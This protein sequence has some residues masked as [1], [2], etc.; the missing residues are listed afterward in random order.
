MSGLAPRWSH[1]DSTRRERVFYC[2]NNLAIFNGGL[3]GA[4]ERLA[5][6]DS[7]SANPV[8]FTTNMSLAPQGGE[9]FKSLSGGHHD[10][11]I[12]YYYT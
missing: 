2:R 12:I 4:T 9:K 5:G 6:G 10:T 8:Q 3:D 7:G 11:S 1:R